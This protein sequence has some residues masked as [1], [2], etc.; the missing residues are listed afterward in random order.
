VETGTP[1]KRWPTIER[2][3]GGLRSSGGEVTY[4]RAEERWPTIERRRGGLP[5]SGGEVAYHRPEERWPTE[6]AEYAEIQ[7]AEIDAAVIRNEGIVAVTSDQG[8]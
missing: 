1:R 3:T 6:Y 2:R 7:K 5:S 8:R 4:H